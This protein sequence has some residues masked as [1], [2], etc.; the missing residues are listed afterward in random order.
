MVSF[1]LVIIEK[2]YSSISRIDTEAS[3]QQTN[4]SLAIDDSATLGTISGHTKNQDVCWFSAHST[5]VI[6]YCRTR[7]RRPCCWVRLAVTIFGF[8][9]DNDDD[10]ERRQTV[11]PTWNQRENDREMN[12]IQE[13]D[14]SNNE[15]LTGFDNR[16]SLIRVIRKRLNWMSLSCVV[17][18]NDRSSA[19]TTELRRDRIQWWTSIEV[20]SP[21]DMTVGERISFRWI[22]GSFTGTKERKKTRRWRQAAGEP[23]GEVDRATHQAIVVTYS[24]GRINNSFRNNHVCI[25]ILRVTSMWSRKNTWDRLKNKA[26]IDKPYRLCPMTAE[27]WPWA[28]F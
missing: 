11:W 8:S 7:C 26:L 5:T 27:R 25:L 18:A 13:S 19:C 20:N 14:F 10:I 21:V 6:F 1:L 3:N 4:D 23:S 24:V 28:Q 12:F 17:K 9:S 22:G 15:Y 16:I 2:P